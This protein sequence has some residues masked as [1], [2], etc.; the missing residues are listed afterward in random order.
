MILITALTVLVLQ[1]RSSTMFSKIITVLFAVNVIIAANGFIDSKYR[2]LKPLIKCYEGDA[3]E[4]A[5]EKAM[6]AH[7]NLESDADD[8]IKL[9]CL[10]IT[11]SSQSKLLQHTN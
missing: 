6:A 9:S 10:A 4:F 1:E 8:L 7:V 5:G 11:V 2:V 3:L